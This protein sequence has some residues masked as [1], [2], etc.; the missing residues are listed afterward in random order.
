M[1]VFKKINNRAGGKNSVDGKIVL[2]RISCVAQCVRLVSLTV[3]F[4][5]EF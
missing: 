1:N 2:S 3:F 5:F 4:Q